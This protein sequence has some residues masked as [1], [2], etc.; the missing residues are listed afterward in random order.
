[1][2]ARPFV[3]DAPVRHPWVGIDDNSPVHQL[4]PPVEVEPP[5]SGEGDGGPCRSCAADLPEWRVVYRDDLWR[6]YVL[7]DTAFP[8]T[9]MLVPHRHADGVAGLDAAELAT[10][11][12]IVAR[13]ST[14]LQERPQGPVGFGDGRV[15]R[16]HAHLWNDGAAHLHMWFF[17]R[18]YGHLD[19]LGSVLVEWEEVLPRATEEQVRAAADDLRSRLQG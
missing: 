3:L 7:A 15:G 11:G 13:I 16:V 6:V 18:P 12:P 8:G 4:A 1:M 9:C 10:F 2:R 14:A 5:R 19:L 17:P